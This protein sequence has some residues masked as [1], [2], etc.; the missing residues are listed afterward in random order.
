MSL[1]MSLARSNTSPGRQLKDV[2]VRGLCDV[3]PEAL[4]FVHALALMREAE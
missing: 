4:S 2:R 1:A 3:Q